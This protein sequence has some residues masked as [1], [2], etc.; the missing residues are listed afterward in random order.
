MTTCTDSRLT[1]YYDAHKKN[2]ELKH[3]RQLG[4]QVALTEY[5]SS[6]PET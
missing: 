3:Q 6:N 1:A 2:I 5:I 4:V